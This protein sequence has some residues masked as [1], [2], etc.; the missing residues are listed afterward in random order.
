LSSEDDTRKLLKYRNDLDNRINS[1]ETE[2]NNL[3]KALSVLD[4]QIVRQGFKKPTILKKG[5]SIKK[6]EKKDDQISIKSKNGRTL[7]V[8]ITEKEKVEFI[9]DQTIEF[10]IEIPPFQTFLIDR[11]LSTM[12]TVDEQQVSTGNISLNGVL[13]YDVKTQN[14]KILK[15]VIKNY[16]DDRR[17]RE[18]SSSIRWVFDKMYDK[19]TQG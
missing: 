3:R 4:T 14:K 6:N 13:S 11:V 10:N 7:G 18:I 9:P 1:L 17:L 16:G 8:I 12:K 5:N 19:I 15:L 2:I